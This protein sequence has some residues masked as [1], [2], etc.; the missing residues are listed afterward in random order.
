MRVFLSTE[1]PA[2]VAW[3]AENATGWDL[4]YTDSVRKPDPT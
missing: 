4:A 2:A 3:F 1:D